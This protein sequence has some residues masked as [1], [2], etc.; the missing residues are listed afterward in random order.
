MLSVNASAISAAMHSAG[1]GFYP[2]QYLGGWYQ[3]AS[4]LSRASSTPTPWPRTL[5]ERASSASN[6]PPLGVVSFAR[7][8]QLHAQRSAHL[9]E[10]LSGDLINL[11]YYYAQMQVGTPPQRFSLIVD[12]GSSVTAVPCAGC[13]RCGRHTNPRYDPTRSSTFRLMACDEAVHCRA[14]HGDRCSYRVSYQE[15]SS[16]SGYLA[17]DVLHIGHGAEPRCAS[18]RFAFG[19]ST[20]ET[21]LFKSQQADGIMG[22]ASSRKPHSEP[23]N[24]TVLEALVE[25][26][27]VANA[28]SLCIDGKI[29]RLTFG[30][31]ADAAG[32]A[33]R[34]WTNVE[35]ANFYSI[36]V[37]SVKIG[38]KRLADRHPPLSSIIDSGTTFMYLHT[39][40][41]GVLMRVMQNR[42]CPGV[43]KT[44]A[45]KDEFCVRVRGAAHATLNR[46]FDNVTVHVRGGALSMPPS[47]YFYESEST[48]EYCLGIFNNYEHTLVLGAIN[49]LHHEITFDRDRGRIGFRPQDCARLAALPG[50]Q[51]AAAQGRR[52]RACEL[53]Q[54]PWW[55][56]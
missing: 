3:P 29:G 45:P 44:A 17:Q 40:A 47:Q 6:S 55:Q 30:M 20:E 25:Q 10:R 9:S 15:G 28:F 37:T 32:A 53:V 34:V 13:S 54:P 19:C 8:Q 26:G 33:P 50:N 4:N 18:L 23:Q 5:T 35:D 2:S 51:H 24:P 41:F 52:E 11:G 49:M 31:A 56:R 1:L 7:L 21:G 27:V 48:S 39:A 14:C 22:L 42:R 43:T 38:S 16:Y 12:T 36:K 46:C